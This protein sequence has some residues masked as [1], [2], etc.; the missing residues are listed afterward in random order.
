MITDNVTARFK[1]A[2]TI[3]NV[4]KEINIRSAKIPFGDFLYSLYFLMNTIISFSYISK[5]TARTYKNNVT[6][7]ITICLI[8]IPTK[9][10]ATDTV[11]KFP[12][13]IFLSSDSIK[14]IQKAK[15]AIFAIFQ[16]RLSIPETT[17]SGS[18]TIQNAKKAKTN[19]IID[20][21]L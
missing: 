1:I 4:I 13:N 12:L 6:C 16:K 18:K 5:T 21:I 11:R 8:A 17:F 19:A 3:I 7:G 10:I 14:I 2:E 9:A 15:T 20:V